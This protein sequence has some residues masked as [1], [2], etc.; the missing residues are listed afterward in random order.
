MR[1]FAQRLGF[2]GVLGRRIDS[3]ASRTNDSAEEEVDEA[4][5][6]GDEDSDSAPRGDE[7]D[8]AFQPSGALERRKELLRFDE[9]A[10]GNIGDFQGRRIRF[11]MEAQSCGE[12]GNGIHWTMSHT[13]NYCHSITQNKM[14]E[15]SNTFKDGGSC[16]EMGFIGVKTTRTLIYYFYLGEN[17]IVW[18]CVWVFDL[19]RFGFRFLLVSL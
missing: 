10:G 14:A 19:N 12:M 17:W 9:V 18:V 7:L 5:L 13:V 1:F 2:D 4:S 3:G 6:F 16:G 15:T 8:E 11:G